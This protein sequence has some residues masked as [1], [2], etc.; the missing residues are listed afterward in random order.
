[1]Q[2]N[3]PEVELS[4]VIPAY[5]A[6]HLIA[7][8]LDALSHE[9]YDAPWEI[10]VVDNGSSDTTP[11]VVEAFRVRLPQLR[12]LHA[13][14]R[15]SPA[16]ARNQGAAHARGR[17]LVFVDADDLIC[18]GWVAAIGTALRHHPF[19]ASRF[20]FVRLNPPW[21]VRGRA[22]GQSSG[23]QQTSYLP[24]LSHA[25]GSGLGVRR[26][27]HE[28]VGGFD[29]QL[30][31]LEDT[32]Y[33]FRLQ[34]AG[35]AMA[36]AAD[37]IVSVRYRSSLYSTFR[38]AHN[39]ARYNVYLAHKYRAHAVTLPPSQAWAAY[40]RRWRGLLRRSLRLRHR[41]DLVAWVRTCGWLIGIGQGSLSYRFPPI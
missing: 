6:A 28:L 18:P 5:N 7:A 29:E 24:H 12:L 36:F 19:V 15:R 2:S 8:Q 26:E 23:L 33:C 27:C 3:G 37:A 25:G 1:M 35:V 14:A 41:E 21:L 38:Q 11:A 22:N 31:Y 32:D 17:S 10:V 40:S 9:R 16:H 13:S 30:P 4:V 39:W 20:E 34:L